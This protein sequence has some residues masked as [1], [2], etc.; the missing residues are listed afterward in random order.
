LSV[1]KPDG[2]L[3]V[4]AGMPDPEAAAARGVRTSG[5]TQPATTSPVLEEL[6]KLV[7]TGKLIPQIGR[8]LPLDDAAEAHATSE[9]GHG[10]GRIVL[11]VP[12]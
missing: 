4:V 12:S 9:T 5:V 11:T 7:V 10:R 2:L 8:V 1:L 6:A 3:V